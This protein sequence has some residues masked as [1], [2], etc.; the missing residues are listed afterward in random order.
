MTSESGAIKRIE[1]VPATGERWADLKALFGAR[2]ACQGCWCMFW[3]MARAEFNR[4]SEERHQAAL[5]A[6]VDGDESPGLLAYDGGKVVGWISIGPRERYLALENSRN[7]KRLDVQSVWSVVCF[8]VSKTHRRKGLMAALLKGALDY[9]RTHGAKIVEG[10]PLDMDSPR[11][12]G[13]KLR[14]TSGYMGVA[15]VFKA[16]GFVEIKRASNTQ[17]VMRY[18]IE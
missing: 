4:T 14:G 7:L 9:A 2:G 8:Y 10:Y 12:A 13:Q 17:V 3:R 1:I 15:S 6:L 11:L 16:V 18:T 5:R